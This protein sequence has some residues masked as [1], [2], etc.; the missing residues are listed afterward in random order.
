[1]I[2]YG[3]PNPAP[4]PRRVR[5]FLAEKGV[6]LVETQVDMSK[7]AHK[8]PAF[9][10]KNSLGQLPTL[11]LDDGVC[12]AESVAICRYL[13]ETEAGP[14]LFGE[15]PLQRALVDMAIRRAEFAVMMPVRQYWRHAHPRTAHLVDQHKAFGE[16]N[17]GAYLSAQ[18]W[19]DAELA[20]RPF[21]AGA[22]YSMADIC[23]L[24]T[25]DF[26]QWIG[27]PMDAGFTHLAAWH[28]RVSDRASSKA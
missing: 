17:R 26:A 5:I 24:T 10:A 25:V 3:A 20:G 22:G 13:D 16:S 6:G 15:T 21:L 19:V 14:T 27:L 12:I 23:L 18:A 2:L 4:N 7:R 11:E 9:V 28:R 8:D 1:M